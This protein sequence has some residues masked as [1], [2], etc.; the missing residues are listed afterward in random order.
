M[1]LCLLIATAAIAVAAD[2][3]GATASPDGQPSTAVPSSTSDK[4][5]HAP[6]QTLKGSAPPSYP[7]VLKGKGQGPRGQ[8]PPAGQRGAPPPVPPRGSPRAPNKGLGGLGPAADSSRGEGPI[9]KASAYE[10]PSLSWASS[11]SSGH[12]SRILSVEVAFPCADAFESLPHC[13]NINQ[14]QS[15][16]DYH[17]SLV[18]KRVACSE[19]EPFNLLGYSTG[20]SRTYS[21]TVLSSSPSVV[22]SS[23]S[24]PTTLSQSDINACSSLKMF[25]HRIALSTKRSRLKTFSDR[26][27]A[28]RKDTWLK[29]LNF[30]S[31][32]APSLSLSL[33][34]DHFPK[35]RY[36]HVSASRD[37]RFHSS[38]ARATLDLQEGKPGLPHC[39][40]STQNPTVT[41]EYPRKV[42]RHKKR[43]APL[44]SISVEVTQTSDKIKSTNRLE[45]ACGSLRVSNT[46]IPDACETYIDSMVCSSP[47]N[48]CPLSKAEDEENLNTQVSETNGDV[49]RGKPG[50]GLPPFSAVNEYISY[51]S[52]KDSVTEECSH[53]NRIESGPVS[54]SE[55]VSENEFKSLD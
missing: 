1:T 28:L 14:S 12:S 52:M 29:I 54:E 36:N 8:R 32:L 43:K 2:A 39:A 17:V 38:F 45:D 20:S 31:N 13:M 42:H 44:P 46:S 9:K 48:N 55:D 37:R 34:D 51:K 33:S 27:Q 7:A 5:A 22:D 16:G 18:K 23:C 25:H 53:L 10:S 49:L 41:V 40:T 47:E 50:P 15:Q 35:S 21:E 3:V 30:K 19:I 26:M 4:N 11:E 24:V 6:A